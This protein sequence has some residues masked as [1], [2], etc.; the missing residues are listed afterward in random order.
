MPDGSKPALSFASAWL[1]AE[2]FEQVLGAVGSAIE[3]Q[4]KLAQAAAE[5]RGADK[6]EWRMYDIVLVA[7]PA[8]RE[9]EAIS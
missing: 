3:E 5:Q 2:E 6:S 1:P 7:S 4:L 9:D 8:P